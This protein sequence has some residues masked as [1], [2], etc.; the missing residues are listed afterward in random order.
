[1]TQEFRGDTQGQFA[2]RDIVNHNYTPKVDIPWQQRPDNVLKQMIGLE[3]KK[4]INA[5][6]RKYINVPSIILLLIMM[7][8]VYILYLV[9]SEFFLYKSFSV[10]ARLSL[11][12]QGNLI[13]FYAFL[14]MLVALIYWITKKTRLE[15]RIIRES[16]INI[17]D[18]TTVLKGRH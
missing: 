1:M 11:F 8:P 9:G 15:N 2:G 16:S 10:V 3:K 17:D 13:Y 7:F 6:K 18:I 12:I 14:G 4:R 5:V